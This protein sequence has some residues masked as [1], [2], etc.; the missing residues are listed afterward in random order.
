[1]VAKMDSVSW[2]HCFNESILTDF[3]IKKECKRLTLLKFLL[4]AWRFAQ[5]WL[6]LTFTLFFLLNSKKV[7]LLKITLSN[8]LVFN[9]NSASSLERIQSTKTFQSTYFKSFL[10]L[11]VPFI[12]VKQ[13]FFFFFLLPVIA[14]TAFQK[15]FFCFSCKYLFSALTCF[16][17]KKKRPATLTNLL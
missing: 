8:S 6:S 1:M 4:K 3:E 7:L 9:N 14:C 10:E 11:R 16:W 17:K 2:N 12:Y 15:S 5:F 13:I